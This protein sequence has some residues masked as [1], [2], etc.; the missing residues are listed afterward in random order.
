[1]SA[2][3][4]VVTGA[5]GHQH[6]GLTEA[7]SDVA[8]IAAAGELVSADHPSVAVA[9]GAEPAL[10]FLGVWDWSDGARSWT[11]DEN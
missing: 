10:E 8:A 5:N 4:V 7:T 6:T 9:R 2:Y 1:M 3:T 11:A